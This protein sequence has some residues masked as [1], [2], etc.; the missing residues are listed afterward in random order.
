MIKQTDTA[1]C[2]EL[3]QKRNTL[4]LN[5]NSIKRT[6]KQGDLLFLHFM[7]TIL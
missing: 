5:R 1:S 4:D 2:C 7:N 3:V 6:Q